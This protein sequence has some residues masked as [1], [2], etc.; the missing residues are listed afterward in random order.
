MLGPGQSATRRLV[1]LNRAA[2]VHH[3][4]CVIFEQLS[5]SPTQFQMCKLGVNVSGAS[6]KPV[7][8]K[9]KSQSVEKMKVSLGISLG[10]TLV[11]PDTRRR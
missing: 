8:Q 10:S 11:K 6:R 4:Y 5:K 3:A 2:T 7:W 1:N 9:R